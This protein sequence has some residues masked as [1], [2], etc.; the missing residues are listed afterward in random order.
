MLLVPVVMGSE[1]DGLVGPQDPVGDL[2]EAGAA[3][4]ADEHGV[5]KKSKDFLNNLNLAH[6]FCL[7]KGGVYVVQ[8]PYLL[9]LYSPCRQR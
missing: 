8:P 1:G 7:G 2:V 9:F 6:G 4:I 5:F 3:G